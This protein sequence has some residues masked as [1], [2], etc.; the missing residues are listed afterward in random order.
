MEG[1]LRLAKTAGERMVRAAVSLHELRP[2]AVVEVSSGSIPIMVETGLPVA[3]VQVLLLLALAVRLLLAK[4]MM[5][6]MR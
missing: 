1:L 6:E 2:V 3:V 4:A 5:A